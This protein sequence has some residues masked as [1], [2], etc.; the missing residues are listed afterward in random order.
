MDRLC[1]YIAPVWAQQLGNIP[2]QR[3]QLANVPTPIHEWLLPGIPN[4]FHV[5]IKRD[6]MTGSTLLGSKVRK[7]EFQMADCLAQG[8]KHVVTYGSLHSNHCRVVATCARELGLQPHL[9]FR[10]DVEDPYTIGCEGNLLIDRL[11][12]AKF[13]LAPKKSPYLTCLKPRMDKLAKHISSETGER[14][15]IIPLISANIIDFWG[16]IHLFDELVMQGA[17]EQFDDVIVAIA[18]GM[19][20]FGLAIGNFLTGSKLRI[21]GMSMC[22]DTYHFHYPNCQ[23]ILDTLGL[24]VRAEDILDIIDGHKGRGYDISTQEELDYIVSVAS[25]TGIMLDPVYTGK[26]AIGLQRELN[27][28]QDMFKGNR[29]LFL[30]TGGVF[31]LYDGRMNDTLKGKRSSTDQIFGWKNLED[32]PSQS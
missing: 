8:S 14:C 32:F 20:A 1:E 9:F 13:Y 2:K 6:D 30:H 7:L 16:Y 21:H 12:S 31:G 25:S 22:D 19:T 18:S 29:I 11:C 26:A 4:D 3:I 23:K 10:T 17:L 5:S 27:N 28:N 24:N 15:Y